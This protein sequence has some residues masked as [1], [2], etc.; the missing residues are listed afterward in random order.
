MKLMYSKKER[1]CFGLAPQVFNCTNMCASL[2]VDFV[3]TQK[4]YN[5]TW[6]QIYPRE[7]LIL[8]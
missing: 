4:Q 2:A 7:R 8:P 5:R 6:H 1:V 3:K